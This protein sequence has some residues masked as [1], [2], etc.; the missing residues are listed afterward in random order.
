MRKGVGPHDGLVW[1]HLDA[2]HAAH[3]PAGGDD[4][5]SVDAGVDA[6]IEILASLECHDDLFERGV[7]GA[8]TDAVDRYLDLP[9]PGLN[10]RDGVGGSH[11]E[12]VMAVNRDDYILNARRVLLDV[13]NELLILVGHRVADRVGDVDRCGALFDGDSKDAAE[14]VPIAAGGILG[15]EFDF[16]D[17][18]LRSAD[19]RASHLHDFVRRLAELALDVDR[20]C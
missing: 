11:A 5:C 10:C 12:V 14:I 13:A 8:L 6:L 2:G 4:L 7:S 17:I 20:R 9:C 19:C 18:T 1:L 15:R 3:E 16:I